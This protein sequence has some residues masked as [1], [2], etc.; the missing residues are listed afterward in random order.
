MNLE[1]YFDQKLTGNQYWI[2]TKYC[3]NTRILNISVDE[4]CNSMTPSDWSIDPSTAADWHEL[5]VRYG[6]VR[7]H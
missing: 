2:N 6:T 4:K 7:V 5:I 1:S 3:I